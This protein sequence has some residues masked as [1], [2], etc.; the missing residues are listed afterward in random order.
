[1]FQKF[2]SI[3]MPQANRTYLVL[4]S[5]FLSFT[6]IVPNVIYA[7]LSE[8]ISDGIKN[9]IPEYQALLAPE[10]TPKEYISTEIDAAV[11]AAQQKAEKFAQQAL[12]TLNAAEAA[13]QAA[14]QEAEEFANQVT[15]AAELANQ[16]TESAEA[17]VQAAQQAAE[18]LAKQAEEI[19]MAAE[20]AE[21]AVQAA[22]QAVEELANPTGEP[23]PQAPQQQAEELANQAG[24][25][26]PQAP[27]QQAE[28]L[29]NQAGEP[30]PQAPQQQ[31]EELANQ[32]TEAAMAALQ[33]A[34]QAA[35]ELAKQVAEA[36]L[37]A[38]AAAQTAQQEAEMFANK[39]AEAAMNAE[40]AVQE[41]QQK[42]EELASK[43][44]EAEE[45]VQQAAETLETAQQDVASG[46]YGEA[47]L[48]ILGAYT[49]KSAEIQ[50]TLEDLQK[51]VKSAETLYDVG[52]QAKACVD[53]NGAQYCIQEKL[54]DPHVP[55]MS[56]MESALDV[57]NL[58]CSKEV[59]SK[60]ATVLGNI[61]GL[62][63]KYAGKFDDD[64]AKVC[65][66]IEKIYNLKYKLQQ[67]EEIREDGYSLLYK[68]D[69]KRIKKKRRKRTVEH[70]IDLRYYPDIQESYNTGEISPEFSLDNENS[71]FKWSSNDPVYLA[72]ILNSSNTQDEGDAACSDDKPYWFKLANRL[73]FRLKMAKVTSSD[74][75]LTACL[76]V[77]WRGNH[78]RELGTVTIP[79]PF[80]YL[81]EL[82]QMKD[83]AAQNA[84]NSLQNQIG[85]MLGI[86][87]K[88]DEIA[89]QAADAQA[90]AQGKAGTVNQPPNGRS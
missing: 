51:I 89:N 37:A 26:T 44:A 83:A 36:I 31:A 53:G 49:G 24:E 21:A 19:K 81:D 15:E 2:K 6:M 60:I 39:V 13:V 30:T 9:N 69:K 52:S 68:H 64:R 4:F 73:K 45:K 32:A 47:L 77:S 62:D 78:N 11:Q 22:Q 56:D 27:Q 43:L 84:M 79:A 54:P 34:Q 67:L 86:N 12:D 80:G 29:A 48:V 7:G 14:K 28:E 61:V 16:S 63:G 82:T 90:A 74:V 1:M 5:V 75:T 46:N 85:D 72:D 35:E 17:A 8:D 88:L 33:S 65:Q 25:P 10:I 59:P 18:E 41:A 76:R 23:T 66:A 57:A 87:D 3:L 50:T 20:S 55:T 38:E 42:K 71:Y 40:A 58:R 70:G